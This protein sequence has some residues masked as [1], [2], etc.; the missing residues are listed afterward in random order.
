MYQENNN[1]QNRYSSLWNLRSSE[2]GRRQINSNSPLGEQ[3]VLSIGSGG[4]SDRVFYKVLSECPIE[5]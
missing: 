4:G 5:T 3:G 2:E 1:E